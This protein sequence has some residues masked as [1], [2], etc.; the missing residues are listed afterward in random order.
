M[1]I[2]KIILSDEIEEL[3]GD[4]VVKSLNMHTELEEKE[5]QEIAEHVIMLLGS[6]NDTYIEPD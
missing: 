6:Q 2:K 1:V 4:C 3:V 5:K